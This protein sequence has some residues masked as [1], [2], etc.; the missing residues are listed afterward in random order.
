MTE[1]LPAGDMDTILLFFILTLLGIVVLLLLVLVDHAR[2]NQRAR[3]IAEAVAQAQANMAG[4]SPDGQAVGGEPGADPSVAGEPGA[5]PAQAAESAVSHAELPD[6]AFGSLVGKRLWDGMTGKPVDGV[7][8]EQVTALRQRYEP[9]L[10]QHISELFME[11]Q[12]HAA[13]GGSKPPSNRRKILTPDGSVPSW[14]PQQHADSVYQAGYDSFAVT[15]KNLEALRKSF[16]EV[17]DLLCSRTE[18]KPSGDALARRL[19]LLAQDRQA[20]LMSLPAP[21]GVATE[22][23]AQAVPAQK[24][25]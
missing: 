4:E 15:E 16:A 18:V 3:E 22:L 25:A 23:P 6:A 17:V 19:V 13:H 5:E 12:G 9:V 14:I 11:G 21:G 8:P 7:E 20:G 1:G 2:A 10:V 24:T